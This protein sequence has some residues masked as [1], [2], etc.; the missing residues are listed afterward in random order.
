MSKFGS[1]YGAHAARQRSYLDYNRMKEYLHKH[2]DEELHIHVGDSSISQPPPFFDVFFTEMERANQA[3]VN[4]LSSI[5]GL[6][7]NFE[8]LA[9]AL[10]TEKSRDKRLRKVCE[11]TLKRNANHIYTKIVKLE[12]F[13]LLNRTAAIKILKKYDKPTG[14][15]A[16]MSAFELCMVRVNAMEIGHGKELIEV[17]DLL[18]LLYADLFCDGELEEANL[19]LALS[20]NNVNLSVLQWVMF[21]GGVILSLIV[22]LLRNHFL[23]PR[24]SMLFLLGSDPSVFVYAAV[25]ALIAYRWFWGFNVYMWDKA[26]V[27]Y[28]LAINLDPNKHMPTYAD[29]YSDAS[30]LTILYLLNILMFHLLRFYHTQQSGEGLASVLISISEYAYLLPVALVA[31]T[32]VRAIGSYA[33]PTSYGVFSTYVASR[34]S[35]L[36]FSIYFLIPHLYDCC[37]PLLFR[38]WR[39]HLF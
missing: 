11:T 9:V 12:N 13:R 14:R 1:R 29:I 38:S 3:Y 26:G 31:G 33:Q 36:Y 10:E 25:G 5:H 15:H 39:A 24:I 27:D 7:E 30:T 21:K 8:L 17:K 4:M 37:L 16:A 19:R 32:L 6:F 20:K 34:V 23:D 2:G 22:I 18:T 28:V 35:V